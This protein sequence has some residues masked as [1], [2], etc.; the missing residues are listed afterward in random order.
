MITNC[1]AL[2]L[3]II[4]TASLSPPTVQISFFFSISNILTKLMEHTSCFLYYHVLHMKVLFI[5]LVSFKM[6]FI[7]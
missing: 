7:A 3:R 6:E 1:F 5:L 2:A 4:A